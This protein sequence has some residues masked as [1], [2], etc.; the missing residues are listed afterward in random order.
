M[1]N[2]CRWLITGVFM[3][4]L[5][6]PLRAQESI[7]DLTIE[8]LMDV[9]VERVFG[10][11]KRLQPVTEAPSSVT[12]VT[13]EDIDRMG[14]RSLAEILR[15]VRGFYVSYDRNY[16]YLGARGFSLPG[17]YNTRV[18]LLIDG[19]RLNDN[20][21]DQA[22]IGPELGLD[23]ATFE[24][25]EIIR[26]PS[27]SLYGT[28]AFF[29]VVN[30][31]T[32]TGEG[33]NGIRAEAQTGSFNSQR[34]SVMAGRRLSNGVDFS[35]A[36]SFERSDGPASLY[37]P[38]YDDPGTN[39]G[40]VDALDDE[41]MAQASGHVSRGNLKIRGA[42]GQREKGVPT[43]AFGT[44]FNDSRFR[45]RDTR[46]YADAQY[47]R[48]IKAANVDVRAYVDRYD[49]AGS[50]PFAAP[51][52][53]D[54]LYSDYAIGSWW[55]VEGRVARTFAR[56]HTV[57]V[58]AEYRRNFQQDQGASYSDTPT[59]DLLIRDSSHTTGS[60]VQDEMA[61]GKYFVVNA[62]IRFD[63]YAGL[64]RVTPRAALIFKPTPSRA[65][66]YLYGRAF[67]APNS[68]E[69]N[70]YFERQGP[71]HAESIETHEA[72]WEEYAGTWLRTS[73]SAYFNHVTDLVKLHGNADELF[74]A[75]QGHMDARG[76]ELEAEV[77]TAKGLQAIGS[78]SLMDATD[79]DLRDRLSNSPRHMAK[80]RFIAPMLRPGS[81]AAVEFEA[82]SARRT[83]S[84][85]D[86]KPM[87]LIGMHFVEPVSRSLALT[88]R[89]SNV[90][91]RR[92]A[93]P[94]S[95]EHA[96]DAI[97]QNGRTFIV[98]LRWSVK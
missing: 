84:G 45:T 23:V 69:L 58:G 55:G 17:D 68:Y 21:Y 9:T 30:I 76:V 7:L 31:I 29:A 27:S 37:I 36:G 44:V 98:G 43:A 19:H 82:M 52:E 63:R 20:M 8:E 81:S 59:P 12:I 15:G 96:Q 32:K 95:E 24:R 3:I 54:S 61:L 4:A 88:A 33:L 77:K 51:D 53:P 42:Y 70:Y 10:A 86:V 41:Q 39:H 71:L 2:K 14:Y 16:S 62:G 26:G 47:Q 79:R 75:N 73:V 40:I 60:Y 57:T 48:S 49:Y 50:Y 80:A 64:S 90:L 97:E 5:A 28:N 11:S 85:A 93:D 74:F 46:G 35:V 65:I 87:T 78:Y 94:G 72:I 66:K 56:L 22:P 18:L 1:A 34:A 89:L 25:V 91:G 92:Y 6:D 67:R 38:A 13:A 83:L